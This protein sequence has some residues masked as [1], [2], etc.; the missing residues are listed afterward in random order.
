M[1]FI[2]FFCKLYS[3]LEIFVSLINYCAVFRNYDLGSFVSKQ[4]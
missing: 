2:I 3:L 1:R 4:V